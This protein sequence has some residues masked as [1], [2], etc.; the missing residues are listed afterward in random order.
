MIKVVMLFFVVFCL[1]CVSSRYDGTLKR[2]GRIDL[3]GTAV[4]A[5]A[6]A[7]IKTDKNEYFYIDG[8][9]SWDLKYAGKK[10]A[11]S[12]KFITIRMNYSDSVQGVK[13]N[14]RVIIRAKY[15]LVEQ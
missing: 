15:V 5:K 12:G 3:L 10:I 4:D 9:S 6:G 14:P 11:L 7:T 8:M 13:G 1:G 2:H